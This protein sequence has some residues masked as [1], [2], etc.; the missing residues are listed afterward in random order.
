MLIA[1]ASIAAAG[2]MGY[3]GYRLAKALRGRDMPP[4]GPPQGG[5]GPVACDLGPNYPGF[6]QNEAGVCT[7]TAATP[8]GIYVDVNCQ[9]FTFV[10]GDEGVQ[11]ADLDKTIYALI[12]ATRDPTMRSADPT[13]NVTLFLQK[14]WPNCTWPPVNGTPRLQQLFNVLSLLIGREVVHGGGRVLGTGSLDDVDEAVAERLMELGMPEFNPDVVPE[15]VL[16][17]YE[18]DDGFPEGQPPDDGPDVQE[19]DGGVDGGIDLPPGGQDFP[20]P[21]GPVTVY[22]VGDLEDALLPCQKVPWS[23]P[24]KHNV[25][26][27]DARWT[28]PSSHD[29]LLFDFDVGDNSECVAYNVRFG[30]C[31]RTIGSDIYGEY[32]A[33]DNLAGV[34]LRNAD[35]TPV[36]WG[37][38][39]QPAVW[40]RQFK[41]R[42]GIA[43]GKA[44]FDPASVVND[45]GV[46]PCLD[47]AMRWPHAS[48]GGFVVDVPPLGEFS[49]MNLPWNPNPRVELVGKNRKVYVRLFYSGMPQ[50]LL[51]VEDPKWGGIEVPDAWV[52]EYVANRFQTTRFRA[53]FK[54]WALGTLPA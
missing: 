49:P 4:L 54:Q 50:F 35:A 52:G 12:S 3:G 15:I 44:V 6:V 43:N 8:P 48:A 34:H 26:L 9:D 19:P 38:L 21:P 14:F 18:E 37:S 24:A 20:E 32:H 22:P 11:S 40:K 13:H 23:P 41:T 33:G 46:D 47:D 5:G 51:G 2:A 29:F 30:L 27:E 17:I 16:P 7:P 53:D 1:A 31:L 28:G 25:A 36:D 39:Q 42:I 10:N 45:P